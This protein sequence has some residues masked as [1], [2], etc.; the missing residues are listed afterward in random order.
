VKT[1]PATLPPSALLR[2]RCC[3][4]RAQSG[5]RVVYARAATPGTAG[6]AGPCGPGPVRSWRRTRT[7]E[8]T[9]ARTAACPPA[10]A[11]ASRWLGLSRQAN[12]PRNSV[13]RPG[14]GG[15]PHRGLLTPARKRPLAMSEEG[16]TQE[17]SSA[18]SLV[19]TREPVTADSSTQARC[20]VHAHCTSV[21]EPRTVRRYDKTCG[22]H[23]LIHTSRCEKPPDPLA[24][25]RVH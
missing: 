6:P 5:P 1:G 22:L 2:P 19:M 17:M 25:S 13:R 15:S 12:Q 20:A 16:R 23:Q 7:A 3:C 9:A 10:R 24:C 18:R 21:D 8:R 11:D 4:G 14:R